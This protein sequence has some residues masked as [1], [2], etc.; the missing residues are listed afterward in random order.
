MSKGYLIYAVDEPYISKAQAL[1]KSI[2]YHTNNDVT[3]ISDNFPYEDITKKSEWHKNT[4]TSN[5]LNLWQ[6]YWATPYDETIVLDA[7]MLFLNDYSYWWD[8]LSKFDL[9]FPNTIINYKQ[10]TIK[11]E[12]YDKILTEHE[13]RPAYEKMFYFKKG[14]EAQELFT[15]LEQVLKNY[16]SISLEIFPNKRPTSLRTSHVFPACIKMLGIEDKVYDKNNIFKY[17][18]MKLSCLNASVKKWDEDLYYWG[19]ITNFYIENFNQYYPL[20]YRNAEI[21]TL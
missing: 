10:E 4:F 2:E 11:H 13:V 21:Y 14:Q 12:Q 17:I 8:Y 7:D 5:L 15:M 18:D 9:L 1:K 3:F 19:D 20:H 6:I 16:R